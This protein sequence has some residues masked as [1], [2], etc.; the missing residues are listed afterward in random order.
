MGKFCTNI[1]YNKNTNLQIIY[2][3]PKIHCSVNLKC[4]FLE[5]L[6]YNAEI[7]G[8]FTLSSNIVFP[9]NDDNKHNYDDRY[10][11][12]T[13]MPFEGITGRVPDTPDSQ[14]KNDNIGPN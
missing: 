5:I 9:L 1:Y 7:N 2:S 14:G 11:P 8:G 12:R 10:E 13:H 4:F 6:W 3:N